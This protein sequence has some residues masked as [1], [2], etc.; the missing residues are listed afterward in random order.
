MF[1]NLAGPQRLIDVL[2]RERV[3]LGFPGAAGERASHGTVV[4]TVLPALIQKTTVGE[5]NRRPTPRVRLLAAALQEAGFL[6]KHI[7]R[8]LP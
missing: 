3:V 5:L 4:A 8:S 7:G 2:G 6:D 1:N